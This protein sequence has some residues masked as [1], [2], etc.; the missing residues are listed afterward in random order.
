MSMINGVIQFVAS[1]AIDVLP[2]VVFLFVFQVFVTGERIKNWRKSAVGFAFVVAGLVFFLAGLEQTL[3][4]FGR[5]MAQQ[6]TD[7]DFLHVTSGVTGDLVWQDYYWV[8]I[9]A[10]AIG[11]STTMADYTSSFNAHHSLVTCPGATGA[12]GRNWR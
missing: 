6:L 11:F 2:V 4:P 9:F 1:S 10:L 3:F 7:P 5:L 8:Y 12:S